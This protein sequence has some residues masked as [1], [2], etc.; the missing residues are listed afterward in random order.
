M[1]T[2]ILAAVAVLLTQTPA[3]AQ[4]DI[5]GSDSIARSLQP[6]GTTRGVKTTGQ[7]PAQAAPQVSLPVL[8][9][10]GS[11]QLTPE[12]RAQL[13][14]LGAALQTSELAASRFRIEGHTDTVGNDGLNQALSARRAQ[15]VVNYLTTRF[16]IE[17]N[18]LAAVGLGKQGLAVPTP[19]QT[20][21]P[22]NRRV[23]VINLSG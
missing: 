16:G 8:F 21:E 13:D 5:V 20:D 14:A 3:W 11:A 23:V 1:R 12:G 19:D 7:A 18:R 10:T 22:R 4:Q 2:P 17:R 15:A 6:V 9:A